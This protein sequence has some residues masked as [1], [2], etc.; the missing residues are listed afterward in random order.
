MVMLARPLGEGKARLMCC[1]V[2]G[3][4]WVSVLRALGPCG[5]VGF[6]FVG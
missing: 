4:L 1:S 6:L 5:F 3:S 2:D